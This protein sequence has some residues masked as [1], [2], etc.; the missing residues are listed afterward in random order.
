MKIKILIST[1]GLLFLTNFAFSQTTVTYTESTEIISNPERGLQKYSITDDSYYTAANYTNL[2]QSTLTGWRTGSDKVTVIF[3]YFSLSAFLS[4]NISEIYLNN[5]QKDFDVIRASGLKCIVRFSYSNRQST[6]PQQPV[7]SMML[8][9]IDQ[10][11][12][13][14][15]NN[16]DIIFSHQAGF[17]GTWG[18]WY[19]TNSSEFG[20][21][22]TINAAQWANRKEIVNA[23]LNATPVEIPLQVRYPLIK[24]TMYGNTQLTPATAYQNTPFARIGFYNDAFLNNWGDMGTY[25]VNSQNQN[26]V[27]TPD[28]NYLMNETKYTPMPGETNGLNP[29]RTDGNNAVLELNLTNWTTL[30]RDYY[31]QNFTNWI[32]SGHYN[33]ILQKLGYRFIL[34]SS[35]FSKN[36]N[37]LNINIK[38]RNVGYARFQ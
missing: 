5:I 18:E 9:H 14:L 7:K 24:K 16:K 38:I 19:Y 25:T 22:G 27:G 17:L 10:I 29:P 34:E 12:S 1:I 8:K 6:A 33:D 31:I 26:P 37:Q 15:E 32:A 21:D 36:D 35:T 28:Y 30:N 2:S 11:A 4:D 3:R 20:T 23:M 13:I